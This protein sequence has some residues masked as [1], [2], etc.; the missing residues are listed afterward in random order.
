MRAWTIGVATWRWGALALAFGLAASHPTNSAQ[1]SAA[2][3]R[4]FALAPLATVTP[5]AEGQ[6]GDGKKNG[7]NFNESAVFVDGQARGILRYSELPSSLKPIAIPEIDELDVPRYFHLADYFEAIG[8]D[9]AKIHEIQIYGSHDRI[10]IITG[11]EIRRL[12]S[13]LVFDFTQQTRGKPRARW[14]QLHTLPHR[15]MV[16]VIMTVCIYVDKPA[17][18]LTHGDMWLDGKVVDDPLPYVGDG[19]PKGTR[20]YAD[21][22]LDGWVRRKQL[23]SKLLAPHSEEVHSTFSTDAFLAWVGADTRNVKAIDFFRG[24]TLLARVDGKT[25]AQ[26]KGEYVFELPT[27][28]H[29]QVKQLFPGDTSSRVTSIQVY[30]RSTPPAR[31]PDPAALEQ[32]GGSDDPQNGGG[33]S[34][35]GDGNG[36]NNG[37]TP[38]AQGVNNGSATADDD[39]F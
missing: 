3:R 22:K 26:T 38:V 13:G 2:P 9:L 29:G 37:V 5:P 10:A 18:T 25:W 20:V 24:D 12:R 19:I 36:G 16:D 27:R 28:S 34:G 1:A 39:Q 21:G 23:P 30:A 7:G 6:H 35:N 14:S 8:V 4:P 33:G 32:Q 15:P 31:Q 11:E 17:P